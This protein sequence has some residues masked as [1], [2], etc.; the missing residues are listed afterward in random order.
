MND[1][2]GRLRRS[3]V[4]VRVVP[5]AVFLA[6][7]GAQD[8]FGEAGRYWGYLVKTAVGAWM[9]WT[10]RG[11]IEEM[12][13]KLSAEAILMGIA[14][15]VLWAG[16]DPALGWLDLSYPKLKASAS[17]WNPHVQFGNGSVLAGFFIVVRL[18]GS[19]IVVPLLEEVFFRSCVYRYLVKADFQ[20]VPLSR[21]AWMPFLVTSIIFGLEHREWLAGILCGFA[22]QGLV[23]WKGRL[24][25]AITAHAITNFLLGL[26][27]VW[28]GAWQF[29]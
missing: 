25:D 17:G 22:F 20:N 9:L 14:V 21:F 28:Q 27:V 12:R 4:L 1:L 11:A 15:F 24:G 29:W 3:P 19:S 13:W 16:L 8:L 18:A 5:F 6:L 2:L 23:L 7:T 10:V 26:W